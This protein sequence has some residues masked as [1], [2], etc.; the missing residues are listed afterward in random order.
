MSAR[1]HLDPSQALESPAG[2]WFS[3]PLMSPKPLGAPP[4]T[5]SMMVP[6]P[7]LPGTM[8]TLLG[9]HSSG[10]AP[11][12]EGRGL[13]PH[14]RRIRSVWTNAALSSP[15]LRQGPQAFSPQGP[16]ADTAPSG[17]APSR[18]GASKSGNRRAAAHCSSSSPQ[19]A[20]AGHILRMDG[21]REE[22]ALHSSGGFSV[23]VNGSAHMSQVSQVPHL[24]TP[25]CSP[26]QLCSSMEPGNLLRSQPGLQHSP[27]CSAPPRQPSRV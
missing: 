27:I 22:L 4:S 25:Q 17:F 24:P 23:Q 3:W 9:G 5:A 14:E 12:D 2:S 10:K 11:W 20:L 13:H 16:S 26:G 8:G 6:A 21:S 15:F 1:G 7:S 18:R 19:E